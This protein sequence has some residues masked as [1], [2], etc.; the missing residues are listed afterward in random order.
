MALQHFMIHD[1]EFCDWRSSEAYHV[2]ETTLRR[3]SLDRIRPLLAGG[4]NLEQAV[5]CQGQMILP[6]L[7]VKIRRKMNSIWKKFPE[8]SKTGGVMLHPLWPGP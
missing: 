2:T 7:D 1:R 5:N 3:F 6:E 4:A 8:S